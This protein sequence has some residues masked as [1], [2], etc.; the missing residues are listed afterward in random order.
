MKRIDIARKVLRN[1]RFTFTR[2]GFE[3][4]PCRVSRLVSDPKFGVVLEVKGKRESVEIRV[5]PGGFL[6]I[7]TIKAPVDRGD[8]PEI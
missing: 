1:E 6:R 7:D 5:T 8:D 2:Y 3:W 4:G